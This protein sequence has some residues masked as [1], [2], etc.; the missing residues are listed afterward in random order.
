MQ[1]K[2]IRAQYSRID[3]DLVLLDLAARFVDLARSRNG[4]ELALDLPLLHILEFHRSHGAAQ[5]V[6]IEFAEGRCRKTKLRLNPF[7]NLIGHLLKTLVDHL[8]SEVH[9]HRVIEYDGDDR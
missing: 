3:N 4:T 8:S 6:L 9:R 2:P 7:W 1:C 5:G